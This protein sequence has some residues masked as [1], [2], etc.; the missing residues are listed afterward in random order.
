MF[1]KKL[2]M[3]VT[4]YGFYLPDGTKNTTFAITTPDGWWL[5]E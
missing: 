3:L 2:F 4:K 1:L 5:K